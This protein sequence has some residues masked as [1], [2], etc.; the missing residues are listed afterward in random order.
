M[1]IYFFLKEKHY[2][3]TNYIK[4]NLTVNNTKA[5]DVHRNIN[6]LLVITVTTAVLSIVVLCEYADPNYE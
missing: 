1:K 6:T 3:N 4:P 5:I 2:M